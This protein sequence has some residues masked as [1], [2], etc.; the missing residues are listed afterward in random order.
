MEGRLFQCVFGEG[1]GE[2]LC[3]VDEKLENNMLID[4]SIRRLLFSVEAEQ[5]EIVCMSWGLI[6][7]D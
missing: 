6:G 7:M 4:N 5:V 2:T 3:C 1:E